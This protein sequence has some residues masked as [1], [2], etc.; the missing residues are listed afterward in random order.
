M[1]PVML[2]G[3]FG[4]TVNSFCSA[5]TVEDL[6]DFEMIDVEKFVESEGEDPLDSIQLKQKL[7]NLAAHD[8]LD[9]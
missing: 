3:C 8:E 7:E 9:C 1:I 6:Y 5:Y 2:S 4:S